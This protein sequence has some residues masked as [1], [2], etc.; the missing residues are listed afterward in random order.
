MTH[1]IDRHRQ[2][3]LVVFTTFH[4][5]PLQTLRMTTW[6][7]QADELP[8]QRQRRSSHASS[9]ATDKCPWQSHIQKV[10]GKPC[11]LDPRLL[12]SF[13]VHCSH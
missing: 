5:S 12:F 1:D 10:W 6:G 3:T 7:S 8:G 9:V 11:D 2:S 13:S 4:G